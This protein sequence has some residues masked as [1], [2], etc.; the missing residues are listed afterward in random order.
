MNLLLDT[1]TFLFW[2]LEPD[3]LSPRAI[4]LLEDSE[5]NL[6]LS[7]ASIWEAM[8]KKQSGKLVLQRPLL[9]IVNRQESENAV[10]ML[11][12]DISH[13]YELDRLP[14]HHKDPFD[15]I[16]IAQARVEGLTIISADKVFPSYPVDVIW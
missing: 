14:L 8:I 11:S 1:H 16:L 7:V 3:K 5:N 4:S 2:E 13:V 12:V 10:R 15:R 9:D 6:W